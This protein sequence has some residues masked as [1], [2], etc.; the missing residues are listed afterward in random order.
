MDQGSKDVGSGIGTVSYE[1]NALSK[2]GSHENVNFFDKP[3]V[4]PNLPPIW[5]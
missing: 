1:S 4:M 5:S 3:H 2:Y